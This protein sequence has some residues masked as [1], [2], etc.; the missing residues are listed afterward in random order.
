MQ[1]KLELTCIYLV[2]KDITISKNFYCSLLLTGVDKQFQDR[3]V[4]IKTSN[5]FIIG[6]LSADYDINKIQQGQD[7]KEHYDR[8]FIKNLSKDYVV[9]NTAVINLKAHDFESEYERIKK[10]YHGG[11]SSIQYVNFMFPYSFFTV[12]DPDGNLIEVSNA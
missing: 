7:L 5:N 4:Q 6:L 9:G 3:W 2:V 11:I 12:K 1:N 8:Q 10:L